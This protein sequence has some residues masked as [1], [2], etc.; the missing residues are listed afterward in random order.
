MKVTVWLVTRERTVW[1]AAAEAIAL[2]SLII[3]AP[4]STVGRLFGLALLGHLA[5]RAVT[6]LPMGAVPARPEGS[7][8]SRRNQDLRTRVVGF[9]NEVRSIEAYAQRAQMAGRPDNEIRAN[10]RAAQRR[11]MAAA[12]EVAKATGRADAA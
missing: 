4:E 2:G 5:Y 9:L 1:I 12:A 10:L 6:G 7:R 8:K 11:M 3:V